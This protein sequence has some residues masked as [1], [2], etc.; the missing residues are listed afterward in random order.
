MEFWISWF[1]RSTKYFVSSILVFDSRLRSSLSIGNQK[2]GAGDSNTRKTRLARRFPRCNKFG[3]RFIDT[4]ASM[5]AGERRRGRRLRRRGSVARGCPSERHTLDVGTPSSKDAWI[6][7]PSIRSYPEPRLSWTILQ[8]PPPLPPIPP[9]LPTSPISSWRPFENK[10]R[11]V[12]WNSALHLFPSLFS[13]S[14]F[15]FLLFPRK[16]W[17]FSERGGG[18]GGAIDG[19]LNLW[20]KL[21]FCSAYIQLDSTYLERYLL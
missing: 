8:P 7:T 16:F 17:K 9:P 6:C 14:F 4:G 21:N 5:P 10:K 2:E 13:F 15:S 18:E 19:V 12:E 11:H 3:A 1:F 20:K